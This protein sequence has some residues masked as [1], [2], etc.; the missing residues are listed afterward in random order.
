[1]YHSLSP[2]GKLSGSVD[3]ARKSFLLLPVSLHAPLS[4]YI[5]DF[6]GSLLAPDL[7]ISY[8]LSGKFLPFLW[9]LVSF[10]SLDSLS[11]SEQ[12]SYCQAPSHGVAEWNLQFHRPDTELRQYLQSEI[13]AAYCWMH[14]KSS[15]VCQNHDLPSCILLFLSHSLLSRFR[16]SYLMR[17][18]SHNQTG[19]FPSDI[20]QIPCPYPEYSSL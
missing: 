4:D 7:D 20:C 17:N 3:E 15:S 14:G 13:R 19:R 11:V 5:H 10:G 8:M 6:C 12:S 16:M 2:D 1:M 18:M 9:K